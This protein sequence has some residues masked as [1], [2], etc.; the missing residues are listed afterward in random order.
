MEFSPRN[1]G[2]M[3]GTINLNPAVEI[4][5]RR[6]ILCVVAG[7]K[8]SHAAKGCNPPGESMVQVGRV[9]VTSPDPVSDVSRLLR[10]SRQVNRESILAW[11]RMDT[12]YLPAGMTD[13]AI[14][15]TPDASRL[16]SSHACRVTA[17]ENLTRP[18]QLRN[19]R[20]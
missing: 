5:E 4:C 15:F 8:T 18:T 16:L 12:R 3:D 11:F 6:A 14:Q 2:K 17:A 10:H 20:I 13:G 9:S 7:M 1:I 19:C